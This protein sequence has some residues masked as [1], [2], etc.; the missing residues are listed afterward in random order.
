M[1]SDDSLSGRGQCN[2]VSTFL[3]SIVAS[4]QSASF[5]DPSFAL[6][7]VFG[8]MVHSSLVFFMVALRTWKCQLLL[9]MTTDRY[10]GLLMWFAMYDSS[11]PLS[12]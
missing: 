12:K 7:P 5:N 10:L 11:S 4:A 9:H 2:V 8:L 1:W 3:Y 6:A